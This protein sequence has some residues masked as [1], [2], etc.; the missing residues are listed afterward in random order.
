MGNFSITDITLRDFFCSS[1][2]F[3]VIADFMILREGNVFRGIA[4]ITRSLD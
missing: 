4:H 2:I 1:Y 3:L